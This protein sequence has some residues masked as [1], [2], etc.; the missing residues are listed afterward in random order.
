MVTPFHTPYPVPRAP[1]RLSTH[2]QTH[3][4][5]HTHTHRNGATNDINQKHLRKH[6]G[7][8]FIEH[9]IRCVCARLRHLSPPELALRRIPAALC[10]C[11]P[12]ARI[13]ATAAGK[14]GVLLSDVA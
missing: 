14:A 5:R 13:V 12:A 7:D 11:L 9:T 10:D 4:H 6:T 2:T 8:A 3:R 1:Y